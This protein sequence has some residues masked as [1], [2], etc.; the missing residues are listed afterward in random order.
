MN[1]VMCYRRLSVGTV[2]V[3]CVAFLA[4]CGTMSSSII[5]QVPTSGPIQQGEQISTNREDQFIRVIARG[6]VEGMTSSEIVQGFLDASASFDGDH[7]VARQYLTDAANRL[8]EP[9]A[10]VAVYEGAGELAAYG[11]EV[12]LTASEAGRISSNGHYDVSA[13]G[14]P[15]TSDTPR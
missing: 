3:L 7:A 4:G 10:G 9:S 14:V 6:P 2:F 5:A 15:A 12:T 13:P 1:D 8:W 11:Y